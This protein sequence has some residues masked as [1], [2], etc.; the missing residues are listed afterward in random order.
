LNH[1]SA[2]DALAEILIGGT[3]DHALHT[4]IGR[5]QSGGG[6]ERIVG[7]EFDHRPH[8]NSRGSQH[9]FEQVELR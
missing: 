8:Y 5:G 1:A 2:A 4:G 7:F 6:C 3:N 9:F